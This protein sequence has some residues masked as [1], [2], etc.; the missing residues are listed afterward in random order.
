VKFILYKIMLISAYCLSN[1]Y[2]NAIT[3]IRVFDPPMFETNG[4]TEDRVYHLNFS[5]TSSEWMKMIYYSGSAVFGYDLTIVQPGLHHLVQW[6]METSVAGEVETGVGAVHMDLIPSATSS[7]YVNDQWLPLEHS[8]YLPEYEEDIWYELKFATRSPDGKTI[9][10]V[11]LF[12]SGGGIIM[13]QKRS[14]LSLWDAVDGYLIFQETVEYNNNPFSHSPFD[15]KYSPTGRFLVLRSMIG[16]AAYSPTG[17]PGDVAIPDAD[18]LDIEQKILRKADRDVAFSSDDRYLLTVRDGQPT[19][20]D[21]ATDKNLQSYEMPSHMLSAVF[22]P[23]DH[24]IYIAGEDNKIYVF[25]SGIFSNVQN[26]FLYDGSSG[27]E[28]LK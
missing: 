28:G 18:L 9:G 13:Q 15:I 2:V 6:N 10:G 17:S 4:D 26:W 23:D 14:S 3:P 5:D 20:V 7:V 19:L 22:S 8:Y 16:I 11:V 25:E 1:V 24:E 27:Q 12:S 21:V